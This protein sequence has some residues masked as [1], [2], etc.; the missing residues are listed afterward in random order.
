MEENIKQANTKQENEAYARDEFLRKEFAK[1]FG[2][3]KKRG[4]YDVVDEI[5]KPT[6]EQ[7]FIELGRLIQR[8]RTEI[9]QSRMTALEEDMFQLKEKIRREINPN[10]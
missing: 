4:M 9:E 1:A 7:I 3:Y 10:L 6:W 5:L 8:Q 2:W